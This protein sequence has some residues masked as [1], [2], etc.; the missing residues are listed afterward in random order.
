MC[1]HIS[2]MCI[3]IDAA[4]NSYAWKCKMHACNT[5]RNRIAIIDTDTEFLSYLTLHVFV[6]FLVYMYVYIKYRYS[7]TCK[8]KCMHKCIHMYPPYYQLSP[9]SRFHTNDQ[10]AV[11]SSLYTLSS[12]S[13]L[14]LSMIA[15]YFLGWL[16]L[17]SLLFYIITIIT[18]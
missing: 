4:N 7:C 2:N 16:T 1:M 5:V 10:D 3:N 9:N 12:L 14:L 11:L 17:S 13:L 6:R 18:N 15:N 8:Y